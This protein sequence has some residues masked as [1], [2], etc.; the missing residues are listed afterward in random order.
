[1]ERAA[2]EH[3]EYIKGETLSVSLVVGADAL[4]TIAG[5]HDVEIEQQTVRIALAVVG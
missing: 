1:M 3:A 5:I 4:A 2:L